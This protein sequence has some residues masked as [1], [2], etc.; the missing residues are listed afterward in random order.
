MKLLSFSSLIIYFS[1]FPL[2]I[3]LLCVCLCAY[4]Y[5]GRPGEGGGV[6]DQTTFANLQ[7]KLACAQLIVLQ[8]AGALK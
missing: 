5:F 3:L 6:F 7:V 2:P 4:I 1:V 8:G